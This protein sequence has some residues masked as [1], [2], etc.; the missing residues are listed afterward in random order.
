MVDERLK[1]S[2]AQEERGARQHGGRRTPG[3]GNTPWRK[4]DVRG[5]IREFSF[6]YKRTDKQQIVIKA[7]VWREQ[8]TQATLDSRTPALGIEVG[9]YDLVLLS[10]DDFE[11]LRAAA[12]NGSG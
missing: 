2:R 5:K 7:S 1:R 6:E 12:A 9:G 3:S 11:A 10:A 4:G 8:F